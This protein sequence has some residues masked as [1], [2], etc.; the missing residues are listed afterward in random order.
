MKQVV[1]KLK[2]IAK[3]LGAIILLLFYRI[4]YIGKPKG[5]AQVVESFNSGGLEQVAANIYK[6]FDQ[7]N[8]KS[9][10][11][12]L[13]NNVG[14]MCQQ[15]RSPSHL[16]IIYYDL[17]EMIKFCGKSNIRV[18]TFHFTTYHMIF[19]KLLGFKNYYIIHN[20][21][22]WYTE[23]EWKK[24]KYKLKFTKGI[25][26]VSE[27]CKNYFAKK[28]GIE[29]I[30][31]IMNGID[32]NNL[33]NEEK[34][35][36]NRKSLKIKE[37]EIV[38]LTIGA[39]TEGKHQMGLIGIAEEVL[40]QNKKVKFICA[41]PILDKKYYQALNKALRESKVKDNF[42][43]LEYIPQ[44]E[45]G[46]FINNNCDIYLQPSV[47][48]AGVP[49]TVMEALLKGK[50]TIMTDFNIKASFIENDFLFGI[51]PIYD[52]IT[53]I[54]PEMASKLSRVT[55]DKNTK[56]YTE[57]IIKVINNMSYY[58]NPK[59]FNIGDFK[60]LDCQRMFKEYLEFIQL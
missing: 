30:K 39:Y 22:I 7:N 46:N 15:L 2:R 21:Y 49:L 26:A 35:S 9:Y 44:E 16:R 47:H 6:A 38:C 3:I 59:N 33:N 60:Y 42:I 36:I 27:W 53:K 58:K 45:I 1:R 50:P 24:L 34:C 8:N 13:S 14:P 52:D 17:A 55:K 56:L 41:G 12:C 51:S 32:F 40:S 10:V 20:T 11:I 28:T 37:N 43:L 23:N 5:I 31:V 48:E 19:L 25:I 29:N 54:T 57:K 18:L 4:K